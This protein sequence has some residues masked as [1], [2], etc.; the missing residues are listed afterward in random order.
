M[1]E[2]SNRK[3][4]RLDWCVLAVRIAQRCIMYIVASFRN[5]KKVERMR[6][7]VPSKARSDVRLPDWSMGALQLFRIC[8]N[9]LA[10]AQYIDFGV[11]LLY[12]CPG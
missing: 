4:Y 8:T 10:A 1:R 9:L 5:R 2:G 12:R 6:S 11:F 7:D 3:V